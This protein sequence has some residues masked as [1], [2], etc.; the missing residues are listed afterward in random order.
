MKAFGFK[1]IAFLLKP[2]PKKK[3]MVVVEFL[4]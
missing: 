1:N 3:V 2:P 4:D